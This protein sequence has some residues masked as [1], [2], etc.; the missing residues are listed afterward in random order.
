VDPPPAAV[1]DPAE[2]LDVDVDQV[3]R[4]VVDVGVGDPATH[5]GAADPGSG[6]GVGP[7]QGRAAVAGQDL[8]HRRDGHGEQVGD[9]G[10]SPPS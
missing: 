9:P 7:G 4:C 8:V 1:G 10:W 3:A 6:R 5:L 2:L